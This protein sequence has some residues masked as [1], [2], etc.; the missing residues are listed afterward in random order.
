MEPVHSVENVSS[1]DSVRFAD[2]NQAS[3]QQLQT[4]PTPQDPELVLL[5]ST[6]TIPMTSHP[7]DLSSSFPLSFELENFINGNSGLGISV[8]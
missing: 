8:L 6:E 1:P 7:L 2:L 4:C 3:L 5:T